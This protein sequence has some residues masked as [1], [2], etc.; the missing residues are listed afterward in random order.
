M[1]YKV[2]IRY[3]AS[4]QTTKCELTI[5]AD[6]PEDALQH[7]NNLIFAGRRNRFPLS[8][9]VQAIGPPT[10]TVPPQP[11][12]QG[13]KAAARERSLLIASRTA[14]YY[15]RELLSSP[16]STTRAKLTDAIEKLRGATNAYPPS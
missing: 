9:N 7:A 10:P 16:T 13:N 4:N 12:A 3:R 1:T 14:I 15:A 5:D 2:T 8:V 11:I 6:A